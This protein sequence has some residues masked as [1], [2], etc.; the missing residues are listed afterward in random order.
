MCPFIKGLVKV[1]I[2]PCNEDDHDNQEKNHISQHMDRGK[3]QIKKVS[4]SRVKE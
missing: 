2:F 4:L 1:E 3:A